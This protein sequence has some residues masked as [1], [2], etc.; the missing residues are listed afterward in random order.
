MEMFTAQSDGNW[1]EEEF[2]WISDWGFDFVRIPLCYRLWIE[3]NDVYQI[4]EEALGK[5]D[6]A[7]ELARKYNLHICLNLHHA[8]GYGVGSTEA[9]PFCLWT[10]STAKEAFCFHWELLAKRYQG[11]S[12]D[13]L[14]FN[15]VNEPPSPGLLGLTRTNHAEVIRAAVEAVRQYQP[16]RWILADGVTWGRE[17]CPELADLRIAQVCRGYAPLG[18]SHYQAPWV[19]GEYFPQPAW[20]GGWEI[21][22]VW[23]RSDLEIYFAPWIALLFKGVGVHC[24]EIGAFNRTPHNIVLAWLRDVLEILTN[25]G[26]GYA[27]WNFRGEFG[28]LD[29]HRNDVDYENWHGHT[30]DRQLLTLLQ[31]F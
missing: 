18:V 2:Q 15:L 20:P 31:K 26:I 13:E 5:L 23:G 12:K 27:L 28:I 24:G 21:F 14:S 8:P 9:E 10:D 4:N 19:W 29:S 6:C 16:Q 17:P 11:I 25:V 1:K 3:N 22:K 7:V 30:L